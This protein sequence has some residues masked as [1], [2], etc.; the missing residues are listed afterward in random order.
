MAKNILISSFHSISMRKAF[1]KF[2]EV[3]KLVVA[4]H[5]LQEKVIAFDTRC[6]L[7]ILSKGSRNIICNV[8]C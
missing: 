3:M 8:D 5:F 4:V 2:V 7:F 6:F 1:L